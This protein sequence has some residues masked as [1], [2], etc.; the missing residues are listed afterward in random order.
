MVVVGD[1]AREFGSQVDQAGRHHLAIVT[2]RPFE[3]QEH[4]EADHV[5]QPGLERKAA[6][7]PGQA[8]MDLTTVDLTGPEQ[9]IAVVG[10]SS[11]LGEAEQPRCV[12]AG[13]IV[14]VEDPRDLGV[15]ETRPGTGFGAWTE[16]HLQPQVRPRPLEAGRC[17]RSR[18]RLEGG[19]S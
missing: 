18:R 7:V 13:E 6:G 9:A 19:Q 12:Q 1:P 16:G 11:A 5:R 3:A 15:R 14:P 17:G 8:L 10:S 2:V 4:L